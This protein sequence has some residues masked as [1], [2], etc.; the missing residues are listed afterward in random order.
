[1]KR[2]NERQER[3]NQCKRSNGPDMLAPVK[4]QQHSTSRRQERDDRQDI[5][6]YKVHFASS[7]GAAAD[8]SHG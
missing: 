7:R 2:N 3:N 6:R 8:L 4:Q 1:M 5:G